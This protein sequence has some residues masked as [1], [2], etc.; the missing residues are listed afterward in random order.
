MAYQSVIKQ[1]ANNENDLLNKLYD[2]LTITL[3]W[4]NHDD[5][6]PNYFVVTSNG[7]DGKAK[8]CMKFTKGS[9]QISVYQ[10]LSWDNISHTGQKQS[11]SISYTY[12][13][14][15]SSPHYYWFYGDKDHILVVTKVYYYYAFYGGLYDTI[16][17][18]D[19]AV[20]QASINSGDNVS[21]NVD[22]PSCLSE[23]EH[24]LI[25]DDNNCERAMI[26]SISGTLVTFEHLNNSYESGARV[27]EDPMPNIISIYSLYSNGGY[28]YPQFYYNGDV[29]DDY[30]YVKTFLPIKD[31]EQFI[32]SEYRYLG[33][34]YFA[35]IM[36]AN[37]N[38]SYKEFL[39]YLKHVYGLSKNYQPVVSEDTVSCGG[40]T[41][42]VF[43]IYNN[44]YALVIP[45]EV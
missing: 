20:T 18:K 3:G 28:L 19:Y 43:G 45:R 35:P 27:G 25:M 9:G 14:S 2:F 1:S 32:E 36:I 30:N 42:D 8:L 44:D 29:G 11:G 23:G 10:Y 17:N 33:R 6:R 39:G 13:K 4:T 34:R 5:Q 31:V 41:Y 38:N 40:K 37:I 24:Y 16:Y 22:D 21:V 15:S 12:I 7:E 26:S